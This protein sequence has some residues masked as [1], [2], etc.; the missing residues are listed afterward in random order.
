MA[1]GIM[2]FEAQLEI[3]EILLKESKAQENR[4]SWL[5]DNNLRTH[6]FMLQCLARLYAQAHNKKLFTISALFERKVFTAT[7]TCL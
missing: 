2:R 7:I 4:V 3:I 6:F 5:F 1:N